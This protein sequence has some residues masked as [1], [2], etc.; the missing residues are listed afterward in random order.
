MKSE[1][2]VTLISVTVYV[3]TM[4]LV[5]AVI[6]V[7][8]TYFYK[9][10]D[11]SS[12]ANDMNK[13]YTKFNSFFTAEV[14]KKDNSVIEANTKEDGSESYI[15][16]SEGKQYTFIKANKG[17]YMDNTKIATNIDECTFDY[18]ETTKLIRIYIKAGDWNKT[19]EYT[20]P[21]W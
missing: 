1:K 10:I 7:I 15:V 16:F 19:T 5:V 8:T 4:L 13:Q 14:N 2:G 21:T 9:N 3:I 20:M 18:N 6:T 11:I 17:I 12:K